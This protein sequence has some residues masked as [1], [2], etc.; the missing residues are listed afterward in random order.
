MSIQSH[1][2]VPKLVSEFGYLEKDAEKVVHD[3]RTCPL[4]VQEAFEKWWWGKG[5]DEQ[6]AVLRYE[7]RE[8]LRM[9]THGVD[10]TNE[11]DWVMLKRYDKI[12]ESG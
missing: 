9:A 1:T 4:A 7:P 5:L 2:I 10:F 12:N 8:Q 6:L 11:I 3:L